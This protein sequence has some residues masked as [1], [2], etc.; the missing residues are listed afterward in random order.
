MPLIHITRYIPRLSDD[1]GMRLHPIHKYLSAFPEFR[2]YE[3]LAE[4]QFRVEELDRFI[5]V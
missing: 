2:E 1:I 3:G 4:G 5:R